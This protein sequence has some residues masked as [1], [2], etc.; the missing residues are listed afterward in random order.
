QV[1]QT[2]LA[3]HFVSGFLVGAQG[4][5]FNVG[6]TRGASRVHVNGNQGLGVVDNDS[7]ARR[8]LHGTRVGGFDLVFDLKAREQ[9]D[10]IAVHL[11]AMQ[12]V[13]HDHAHES[14]GLLVN[15]VRVDQ[16]FANIGRE[17]IADGPDNQAGFQ[18]NQDRSCIVAGS[19]VNGG[20]QL[21]Q[22]V[23]VPL[24]LFDA[25]AD[26]CGAGD[27]AHALRDVQLVHGF[28]QFLAVFAFNA[29][30]YA[31][32]TGVV[33]HQNQI[34]ACQGNEGG[35]GSALVATLFFFNLDD[36]FLAFNQGVLDAGAAYINPFLEVAASYFLEWQKAVTLFTVADEAGFQAGFDAGDDPFVD[37]AFA[38]FAPG[39]FD[40]EVNQFLTVD[41]GDA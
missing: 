17:V 37:I 38:L 2:Q 36:Q 24:Q 14:G 15:F 18:I 32:P 33:G 35:Q 5:F 8:Q 28:A 6:T 11:Y 31:T 39:C 3:G 7:T 27:D 1:T 34:A 21:H 26:T 16:D 9:R 41:N 19:A 40:V 30:R 23:Q 13:G 10:V 22:V 4:G 12:I 25:A 20:P 29:A